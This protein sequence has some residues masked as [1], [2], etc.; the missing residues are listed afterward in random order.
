[1]FIYLFIASYLLIKNWPLEVLHNINQY[2]PLQRQFGAVSVVE[3]M[4]ERVEGKVQA[5]VRADPNPNLSLPIQLQSPQ[6]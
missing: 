1:M 4:N 5:D 3:C 2:H 6:T